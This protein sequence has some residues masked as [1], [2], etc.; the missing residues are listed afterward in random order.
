ME[1][2]R[3]K[4]LTKKKAPPHEKAAV[5]DLILDFV[6]ESTKSYNYGYWLKQVGKCT[7][8]DAIDMIKSL[9]TLPL[10]YNKGAVITNKLKKLNGNRK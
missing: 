7:F 9:E 6:G 1:I 4:Y 5:V 3:T 10:E 8:S 2:D